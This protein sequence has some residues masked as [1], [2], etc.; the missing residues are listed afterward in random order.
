LE[1]E[2]KKMKN[3]ILYIILEHTIW[4][5]LAV[6]FICFALFVPNFLNWRIISNTL[7]HSLI[8]NIAF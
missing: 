4:V 2:K 7:T 3:W 8:S 5:I 6:V 1:G